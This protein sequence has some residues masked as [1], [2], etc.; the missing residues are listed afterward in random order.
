MSLDARAY[1]VADVAKLALGATQAISADIERITASASQACA[2]QF[3]P[4]DQIDCNPYQVRL[5]DDPVHIQKIADDVLARAIAD[6]ADPQAGLLQVPIARPHPSS[7][8]RYQL[9]FGHTRLAA[10][11]HLR[12]SEPDGERWERFPLNVRSLSDRDLAE[13]A[14]RENAARKDLSAIEIARSLQRL[15]SDF[16]LTQ[17][18]AGKIFGYSSQGAVANLL[19]LLKLPAG[20]NAL[21]AP[22]SS[23]PPA[24][25]KA[26]QGKRR[27]Q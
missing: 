23:L 7:P 25:A 21:P 13:M 22:A 3:I 5:A 20:W 8:G 11:R 2:P 18:E 9:A 14:A 1:T 10:F 17:L 12:D 24:K 4:L 26:K 6:P 27:Q 16:H 15:I 19:R